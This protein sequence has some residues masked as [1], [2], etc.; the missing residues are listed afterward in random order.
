MSQHDLSE[1]DLH[2]GS[3]RIR[4][5]RGA[6]VTTVA[7]APVYQA[8]PAPVNEPKP[9]PAAPAAAPKKNLLEIK[10]PVVGTFYKSPDPNSPAFVSVGS[11][12]TPTTTVCIIEAM[13]IFN[14]IAA[15]V[16]GT[17]VE[18]CVENQQPVEY[19]QVL[20]RVDPAG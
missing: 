15:E 5:R 19:G 2:D 4:L 16:A 8:A 10:S 3:Q 18:L 11:K 7:A 20:F 9:G 17:I 6:R 1:I 12:V 14:E 13:K